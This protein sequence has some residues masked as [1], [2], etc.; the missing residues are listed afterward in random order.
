LEKFLAS[1][2]LSSLVRVN[3]TSAKQGVKVMRV[4]MLYKHMVP[5]EALNVYAKHR[6]GEHLEKFCR[7]NAWARI[8]VRAEGRLP[9]IVCELFTGRGPCLLAKATHSNWHTAV[10]EA[11]RKLE[12]VLRRS[13][14]RA[15]DHA[16]RTTLRDLVPAKE[17]M[18]A[19]G[20]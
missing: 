5:S 13:H 20:H 3:E 9:A 18:I 1:T 15:A 12:G 16:D 19:V 14:A 17:A 4:Q 6:V 10:D 8:T 2:L 7:A 11:V